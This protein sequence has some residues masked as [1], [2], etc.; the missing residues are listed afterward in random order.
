MQAKASDA[1]KIKCVVW[2]LDNTIWDG[3]L[4]EGDDPILNPHILTAL[5]TL[6]E[7]G[8]LQSIASR[9]TFD[10]AWAK[11]QGFGIGDFFLYPEIHWDSKTGSI[12]RIAKNLNISTDSFAFID[13]QPFE[14]DEVRFQMPEVRTF[15]PT[16]LPELLSDEAFIPR[17][18]TDESKLRRLMYQSDAKRNAEERTFKGPGEAFLQTLDMKLEIRPAETRDLQRAEELTQRTHQLN[19]TGIT[20]S[21]EDLNTLLL[22]PKHRLLVASLTDRYG[23]YGTIG[24]VLVELDPA[25]WDIRLLLMS[26]RVMSRGVGGAIITFL[27]NEARRHGTRLFADFKETDRNRMMYITYKFSGFEDKSSDNGVQRMEADLSN[28]PAYPSYLDLDARFDPL[29]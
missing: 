7:R 8:I 19:T 17:F 10:D 20:Y 4:S 18:I 2:D 28:I 27:R 14:R 13:D 16:D 12:A 22:S 21:Y 29:S 24:L 15:D 11:I 6:D 5:R 9:N 3:T 26:C 1:P 23:S 25:G